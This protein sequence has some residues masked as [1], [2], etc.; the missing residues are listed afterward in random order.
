VI[1]PYVLY[2]NEVSFKQSLSFNYTTLALAGGS[3]TKIK[4]F[5]LMIL[6]V[7]LCSILIL[8]LLEDIFIGLL[9]PSIEN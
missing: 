4:S 5:G 1:C 9:S 2:I 8:E 6:L 3:S 7:S